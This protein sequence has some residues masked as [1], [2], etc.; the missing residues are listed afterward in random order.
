MAWFLLIPRMQGKSSSRD[1]PSR[2]QILYYRL[3]RFF[4]AFQALV[5]DA[6]SEIY[7]E[8]TGTA[9]NR[10]VIINFYNAH[11][12]YNGSA[13]G[14]EKRTSSQ[15]ILS[16]TTDEI[17]VY[18][19]DRPMPCADSG[20]KN[21]VVGIQNAT[22]TTGISPA[23]RNT[24]VWETANEA[25]KFSPSGSLVT[26]DITWKDRNGKILGYGNTLNIDKISGIGDITA[27]ASYNI[28]GKAFTA[29]DTYQIAV[30][31]DYPVGENYMTTV[32]SSGNVNLHTYIPN[33]K[34]NNPDNFN[35]RFF[36]SYA[37]AQ[38]GA[39]TEYTTDNISSNITYFVR[40]ENKLRP[41]C[42]IVLELHLNLISTALLTNT[43]SVCDALKD[44]Y[45]L[46]KFNR[47]LIN[48][49]Y[50]G[51]VYYYT[52]PSA[53]TPVT[54]LTLANGTKL[55]LKLGSCPDVLGP[56]TVSLTPGPAVNTPLTYKSTLCDNNAD[57]REE[58]EFNTSFDSQLVA[59]PTLYDIKY[60]WYYEDALADGQGIQQIKEGVY[61]I[62]ARVT[63]KAGGCFS[64]AEI[65]MDITFN[66]VTA[67]DT[68]IYIC[69]DGIS[70]FTVDLTDA[71]LIKG[72]NGSGKVTFHRDR[73][74]IITGAN[75]ITS[76]TLTQD[77]VFTTE[78][79][80]VRFEEGDCY[81]GRELRFHQ[82]NP[83]N[84]ATSPI[85]V[86]DN[87]N[88]GTEEVIL[89]NYN[90]QIAFN[91]NISITYYS[92]SSYSEKITSKVLKPGPDNT[93]YIELDANYPVYS[94]SCKRRSTINFSLN[95][96]PAIN[97]TPVIVNKINECDN[98]ADGY[99]LFDVKTQEPV[100][101]PSGLQVRYE[102]YTNYNE[103][104][105]SFSN[106]ISLINGRYLQVTHNTPTTVFVKVYG[107]NGCYSKAEIRVTYTFNI[108]TIIVKPAVLENCSLDNTI[109]F[110]LSRATAQQFIQSENSTPLSDID[111]T[112]FK[113]YNPL[114]YELTDPI[115]S[116][117]TTGRSKQTIYAKYLSLTTGCYSVAPIDL[118]TYLS[119]IARNSRRTICEYTGINLKTLQN[120]SLLA[121]ALDPAATYTYTYYLQ[122]PNTDPAAVEINPDNVFYPSNNQRIWFKVV[123][124]SNLPQGCETFGFID[125]TIAPPMPLQ[126]SG[127]FTD[128][129]TCDIGNDGVETVTTLRQFESTIRREYP[130]ASFA[131]YESFPD[132][133]INPDAYL[134][135]SS[136]IS[137][138]LMVISNGTACPVSVPI[139]IQLK[140]TP[141]FTMPPLYY[142]CETGNP[143]E[144]FADVSQIYVLNLKPATYIWSLPDGSKITNQHPNSTLPVHKAG[145]YSLTIIADNGCS[146]TVNFEGRAYET[147]EI[148]K[149]V[150]EDKRVTVLA[151]A[152][153]ST[154]KILYTYDGLGVWQ[155]SYIFE[156][157]P[158]GVRTFYVRYEDNVRENGCIAPAKQ[159]LVL[160]NYNT[161][162][163]NGDGHNDTLKIEHLDF[164]EGQ[165]T[166]LKIF[167]RYSK[168]VFEKTSNT[169]IVWDGNYNGRVLPTNT[170]WYVL[171]LPDGRQISGW[172]L[173]K[174]RN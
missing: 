97:T 55:W 150:V 152:P 169:E 58:F 50:T 87:K 13:D 23:G 136:K 56:V 48:P 42:F 60:F 113:N 124:K 59:D 109:V 110:D 118:V 26:P 7:V 38:S 36:K 39:G 15:I 74:D 77:G 5:Y 165:N 78:T 105:G 103:T 106:E 6:E 122:D 54:T 20:Y 143:V 21:A 120:G 3:I 149:L 173:L 27:E 68:D 108:N 4:G 46:S 139:K 98:N 145:K 144:V 116:P 153:D 148:Y 94:G 138:I 168:L 161:I 71:N 154:R 18:I 137:E 45:I 151:T 95:S 141:E 162:T 114:T 40:V 17:L 73:N 30:A 69:Y 86:C 90:G 146:Y 142:F 111:I 37:D 125:F 65:N 32:C 171:T 51:G 80:Y 11:Y 64:I 84:Y 92:D 127:P 96:G 75:P 119:P 85:Q 44:N 47:F 107:N 172:I 79:V 52:D 88:D 158:P 99:E 16:E 14:C 31:P 9:P 129:S 82:V 67:N 76:F 112:Y 164:F 63:D 29:T 70:D 25:W 53:T 83:Q 147:P 72:M 156:N 12:L 22:G 167:D 170:Y 126:N 49:S 117:Y 157:V 2:T 1:S 33:F 91:Q 131:Y 24:G 10:K 130:N 174:N 166:N 140:K 115:T 19:K 41:S 35:F 155:E 128:S 43:V 8:K 133:P 34:V 102:Y 135:D 101:N 104:S 163:P 134:F 121:N 61:K 123:V 89:Q 81:T 160:T 28:C 62:Y 100:I 93:V 159:A 132:K 57:D 66:K